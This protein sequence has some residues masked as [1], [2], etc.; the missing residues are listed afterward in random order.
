MLPTLVFVHATQ[1][2]DS[3]SGLVVWRVQVWRFTVF[4]TMWK[5]VP[6]IAAAHST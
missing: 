4:N 2:L 1:Q 6:Q 5:H 3:D